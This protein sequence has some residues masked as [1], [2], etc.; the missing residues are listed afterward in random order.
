MREG[1]KEER[2]EGWREEGWREGDNTHIHVVYMCSHALDL[3]SLKGL[4]NG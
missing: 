3:F 4:M 2:E 1:S